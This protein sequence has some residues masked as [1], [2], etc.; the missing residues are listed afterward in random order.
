MTRYNFLPSGMFSTCFTAHESLGYYPK[1]SRSGSSTPV[2][3]A[4]NIQ[5]IKW[6]S[7]LWS[8]IYFIYK[9]CH[10]VNKSCQETSKP[11]NCT[12]YKIPH[13][14]IFK[15]DQELQNVPWTE[16]PSKSFLEMQV[17]HTCAHRILCT[18][19]LCALNACVLLCASDHCVCMFVSVHMYH[20]CRPTREISHC[21]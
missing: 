11:Q 5:G 1:L 21:A 7:E 4:L 15:L 17:V 16:K 13:L 8:N 2:F 12:K 19:S 14:W 3:I 20:W 18:M 9:G 6:Y 10:K